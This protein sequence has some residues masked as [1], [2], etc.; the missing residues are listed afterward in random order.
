MHKQFYFWVAL[1]WTGLIVFFCLIKS[2]D[3]PVVQI[4][5][6]DKVVHSFFHFMFTS[7]WF[8]FFKK[9]L[10]SPTVFKPLVASVLFSIFFGITIEI[11]QELFTTTRK[12]DLFDVLANSSGAILAACIILILSKYEGLSKI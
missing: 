9:Q 6:L 7:F 11:A 4:E 3:I 10:N 2:S 1:S 5:N 8:L 12:G